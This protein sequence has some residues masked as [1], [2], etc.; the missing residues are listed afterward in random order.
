VFGPGTLTLEINPQGPA[1]PEP[2]TWALLGTAL[3]GIA[4][5]GLKLR[6]NA[7]RA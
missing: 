7:K 6:R 3:L 2:S 4:A 1:V 5:Y